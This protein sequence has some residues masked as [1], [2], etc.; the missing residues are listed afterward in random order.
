M[1]KEI[2][3]NQIKIG[4]RIRKNLRDIKELSESIKDIGLLQSI[5]VDEKNNL[6]AGQRR[7][8]ACKHIG[9]EKIPAKVIPLDD[10]QKG[11]VH[12]NLIRE[13]FSFAEKCSIIDAFESR[14]TE[15]AKHRMI[16]A[17]ASPDKLSELSKGETRTKMARLLKVSEGT[18]DKIKKIKDSGNKKWIER[19]DSGKTS[20]DYAFRMITKTEAEKEPIPLPEGE[21]DI[22][23]ADPPWHYDLQLSGAPDYPTMKVDDICKLKVP[24]ADDAVLLLWTTGPKLEEA[25][26]VINAW[27]FT[28]KTFNIWAKINEDGQPQ[29]GIGYYFAGVCEILLL[30]TKGKPGTPLPENIPL[31][32]HMEAKTKHSKK[33]DYYY[34][35]I[36]KMFPNRH[37]IE[38][39]A[40]MR[41]SEAWSVWGFDITNE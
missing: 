22:I 31:G 24:S 18:Y 34:Q 30:A 7:L 11:Q 9:W 3:I 27:G 17:H 39:F 8:E 14:M 6:I 5:V 16:D 15:D 38:L 10:I 29:R 41:Y 20:I 4:K 26:R 33:P 40:R 32:I 37:Y 21:F 23:Y 2:S 1:D 12:E 28:Y 36:E 25:F 19:V 35:M 13:E